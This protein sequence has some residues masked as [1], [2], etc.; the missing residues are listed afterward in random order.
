MTDG[1]TKKDGDLD[2]EQ[3]CQII[4]ESDVAAIGV[5]DYFSLESFF[6]FKKQ[7]ASLYPDDR[8][9]VFFPNLELRLP[10]TLNQAGQSVNIHIVFRPSLS[11]AEA[12]RFLISLETETTTGK[13]NKTVACSDLTTKAHYESATV[14]R[15]SIEAALRKTFGPGEP[16]ENNALI[17]ASA[18][19]DG[20]RSGGKSSR[21]RKNQ[22]VDEIDKLSHGFFAGPRSRDHF[23]NVDRLEVDEKVAPK[24]IFDG[25]DAH[26]F[27]SLRTRLGIHDVTTEPNSHATWVKADLTYEGLLQTLVE[28]AHRVAM[29]ALRPDTK[30]PYQHIARIKFSGTNDFPPDVVFNANL[31]AIIGSRSSGK[32]ALLAFIAHAVDPEDAI[33]QQI[34]A[35]GI[36]RR[37]A[38]PA[39]GLSWADV[40]NTER[41]V[42]WGAAG[43]S[44]GK[45]IYI[46]QNSLYRL[47]DQPELVTEKIA[48]ALFRQYPAFAIAY[49]RAEADTSA[50]NETVRLA[51]AEWFALAGKLDELDAEIRDLGDKTAVAEARDELKARVEDIKKRSKLSQ[52]EI[53]KYQ[54]V[55]A[56]LEASESRLD[57]IE[58][59]LSVLTQYASY[60]GQIATATAG[61]VVVSV[62]MRPSPDNLPNPLN[63]T[64]ETLRA[65][66]AQ[67]LTSQVEELI[68]DRLQLTLQE[69]DRLTKEVADVRAEYAD[70]IEKHAANSE[71]DAVSKEYDKQVRVLAKIAKK[72][73]SRERRRADQ[74]A[75]VSTILSALAS[76]A[77][78]LDALQAAFESEPRALSD[79][80]TFGLEVQVNDAVVAAQS[81]AYNR[82]KVTRYVKRKGDDLDI[83]LA[84]NEPAEFLVALH[85]GNQ[86]LNRGAS[87]VGAAQGALTITPEIRFTAELDADRIGGFG[88][89]TMTPG[90]RALFAL[91][92]ILNESQEPW[93]LLIDQPEDDLDSRSIYD[94][95]VPYLIERKRERQIIMVTHDANLAIGADSEELIVANRHGT[96][97]PNHDGRTFEYLT[98]A[99][100]HTQP[101]NA[102]SP[103]V[104]GRYGMREHA[105]EIL[106]GGEEAFQ[107]RKDKY[108][109]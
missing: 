8:S 82:V 69:K 33:Q 43:A 78:A 47:S 94:T 29:G 72:E 74:I 73:D 61:R 48:P 19:G 6:Q 34:S 9:K 102:K 32:S 81:T 59:D 28:P 37:A 21:K 25:C 24:P 62:T 66:A 53:A 104:L 42:E 63:E 60:D 3:F 52:E 70:L 80:L 5:T 18:K 16:I 85:S 76:R 79:D 68:A 35:F 92:L 1:Y 55:T 45:V 101:L 109:I 44:S 7:Y 20:I 56:G 90:K 41:E 84:Q 12:Q 14:S 31:N 77:K 98:G 58:H 51:V 83:E 88:R 99:L 22:L 103:T 30:Q 36:D 91:T 57:E 11:E 71:L 97:R 49:E 106:D 40:V 108:K 54:A 95:I 13:S 38:G 26:S 67:T 75:Q 10:E 65:N 27:D 46:P 17:I 89:S 39:A 23:L 50:A 105:C 86:E 96:D 107:K 64:V 100:E 87:R 15:A 2:W 93:P 4:H